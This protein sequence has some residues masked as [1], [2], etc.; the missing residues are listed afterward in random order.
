M[1]SYIKR[2]PIRDEKV[3]IYPDASKISFWSASGLVISALLLLP[4]FGIWL[5]LWLVFHTLKTRMRAY[6]VAR[7]RSREPRR[8]HQSKRA[9]A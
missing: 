4:L 3:V 1:A 7:Q 2:A 5:I 9:K 6:S 8:D